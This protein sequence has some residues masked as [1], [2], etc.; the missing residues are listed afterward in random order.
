MSYYANIC[1]ANNESF[2]KSLF[3]NNQEIMLLINSET[4]KIEDCN[5]SACNFYGYSYD[6]NFRSRP[7]IG[8]VI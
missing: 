5:L 2:Y 3:I 7:S 1:T 6:L 8:C 4:Y